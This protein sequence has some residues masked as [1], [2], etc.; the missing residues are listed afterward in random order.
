[1]PPT[2]PPSARRKNQTRDGYMVAVACP[3]AARRCHALFCPRLACLPT[4]AC[5]HR[6]IAAAESAVDNEGSRRLSFAHARTP[7]RAAAAIYVA[8]G[9]RRYKRFG[10]EK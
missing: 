10:R 2:S 9:V 6:H 3:I 7:I 4:R 5:L 1:V 8:A